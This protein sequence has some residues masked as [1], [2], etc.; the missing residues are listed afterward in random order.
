MDDLHHSGISLEI[1]ALRKTAN[2]ATPSSS[3]P[4]LPIEDRRG[5][6]FSP[7][8]TNSGNLGASRG[9]GEREPM[10][11]GAGEEETEDLE[12][13]RGDNS[14]HLSQAS[15]KP[16][17]KIRSLLAGMF[18]QGQNMFTVNGVRKSGGNLV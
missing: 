2:E 1:P 4:T 10:L 15:N 17:P 12:S 7:L 8:A 14:P 11:N 16:L 3:E 5:V 18:G 6:N 9:Q 13:H